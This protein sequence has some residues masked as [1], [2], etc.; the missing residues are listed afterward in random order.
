MWRVLL[1]ATA[2]LFT[3][4]TTV[5]HAGQ[6]SA[7]EQAGPPQQVIVQ[8]AK[9]GQGEANRSE[10]A[11]EVLAAVSQRLSVKLERVRT[12][13]TGA[14]LV[15]VHGR[16][17]DHARVAQMLSRNP[18]VV[19]AEVDQMLKPLATPNDS[20]YNEQWHYFEATGGLNV[21]SAWDVTTGAGVLVAVLDTGYRP[22][23]DLDGNIV[24]GYDF[25][26]DS[27]VGNDG[28]GRDSDARDPGDWAEAGECGNGQ[29]TQFQG[30]SWHGTHVAGTVAA[31]T[32]N[33][34]GVA[35]VAYGAKVV[36]LR[37]LGK[38][39][40]L[41][42]D[43]ADA[44]IWASG[45]TV[46]GV[47]TNANPADVINMSLGGG[48]S[49]SSTTQSAINT[50]RS[51]GAVVIVAA[52]NSNTNASNANPANC[53]GV[54]T[55]AATNRDGGR[56]YYS[57]Y[58]SVVDV[59]APGG[60]LTQ[61]TSINGVLSTFNSGSR[62]PG[63]DNYTFYQGTSMAAPHVAG[64]AALMM[65][66]DNTLSPDDVE[67]ILKSTTRAFPSTCSQ[68]GTGIVDATAA[69]NAANGGG[70]GGGG[71]TVLENGVA[72]T[73]LSGAQGAELRFTLEVPA[74]ATD[75]S[76]NMSGG[77][78]DADLYVKFG[79]APT[80]SS[81][82][83]RPYV[84]GNSES[85]DISNVQAGT[86]HVMIRGYSAFSNVSLVGSFT[87]DTGGGGGG[88]TVL[89]NGVAKTDLSG[90]QGEELL[91][92]MDVPAGASDLSF[93]MS[94]GSGDA[95]LY[96]RFGQAPTT[97]SYDCRP[98]RSGNNETCNISNVQAG[99]YYVMLRG[100]SAFSGVSLTGSYTDGG[101]GG[102]G[103]NFFESTTNVSIP[104]NGGYVESPISVSRTG[105]SGSIT[106]HVEIVHTYRGDLEVILVTP[107]G[108]TTT[109]ESPS[110][111]S[112]DNISKDYTI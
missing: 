25:I 48:G 94:G 15:R 68:C 93:V 92:T 8:F 51:N 67:S 89:D 71:D 81:Y 57:N 50:A 34:S 100:Y 58:G 84:G 108:Q 102:G 64:V 109:L 56:S 35:G 96:V 73:G 52:G 46:S 49:C 10:R 63:S 53:A 14:D 112:A 59:G 106:V 42:S 13:G 74:G 87:E 72:E 95:D 78:G 103:S 24:G 110:N 76:F 30:S 20:R 16:K 17:G 75:L 40:G 69:V 29:P 88:D 38:C 19:Y 45:G 47:P 44:I 80:T 43:I 22:H 97:S 101:S 99:T 1:A 77:S 5:A 83:C 31:E 9:P 111:D 65:A 26:S 41:T 21:D 60:E 104:D 70:G 28:D 107:S 2:L 91:F 105:D 54:V 27:F 33:S 12:L 86:Y 36:P 4:A 37:V 39:G 55:V 66:V 7:P 23:V 6:R 98:Y 85:C 62:G 61:S 18:H 82:D 11:R 79:S 90:A 32:N 3:T